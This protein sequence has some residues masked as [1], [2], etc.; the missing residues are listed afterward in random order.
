MRRPRLT[1][2]GSRITVTAVAI[3]VGTLAVVYLYVF[4]ISPTAVYGSIIG[5]SP[6]ACSSV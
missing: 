6:C 2:L 4:G 1:N 3:C 5:G